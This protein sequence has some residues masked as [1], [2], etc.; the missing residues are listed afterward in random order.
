MSE[1]DNTSTRDKKKKDQD[2]K[3]EN[4]DY[5]IFESREQT[6]VHPCESKDRH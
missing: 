4:N 2:E 5:R 6:L 1:L 3:Q